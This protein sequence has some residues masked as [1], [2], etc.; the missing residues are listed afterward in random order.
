MVVIISL[1][2][3]GIDA[4]DSYLH[5]REFPATLSSDLRG[6]IAHEAACT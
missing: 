2:F 6:R 5:Y 4:F 1:Q 3:P